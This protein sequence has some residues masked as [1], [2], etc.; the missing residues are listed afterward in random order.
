MALRSIA[1]HGWPS[2]LALILAVVGLAMAIYL[3]SVREPKQKRLGER[4]EKINDS[5]S[6]ERSRDHTQPSFG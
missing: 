3:I 2:A 1:H 5:K 4:W 6:R